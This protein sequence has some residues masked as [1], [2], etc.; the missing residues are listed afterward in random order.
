MDN[1]EPKNNKTPEFRP[2]QNKKGWFVLIAVVVIVVLLAVLLSTSGSKAEVLSYD[3]LT[4]KINAGEVSGIYF[5]GDYTVNVLYKTTTDEAK[6]ESFKEGDYKD[7]TCIVTNRNA[8]VLAL[9]NYQRD[10]IANGQ[11]YDMPSIWLNDP[12]ARSFTSYIFPALSLLLLA[13]IAD[14]KSV[15]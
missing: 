10:A 3:K 2:R 5:T 12:N 13:G 1:R 15:V 6:I 14:R 7:A 8:L 11:G 9:E 4:G